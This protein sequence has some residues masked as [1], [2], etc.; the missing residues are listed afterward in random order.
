MAACKVNLQTIAKI[1]Q[2][3]SQKYQTSA[4]KGHNMWKCS[5]ESESIKW[6]TN[7]KLQKSQKWQAKMQLC[8][9]LLLLLYTTAKPLYSFCVYKV[10]LLLLYASKKNNRADLTLTNSRAFMKVLLKNGEGKKWKQISIHH[11]SV[12]TVMYAKMWQRFFF[13][14]LCSYTCVSFSICD[15][16][17]QIVLNVLTSKLHKKYQPFGNFSVFLTCFAIFHSSGGWKMEG[18]RIFLLNVSSWLM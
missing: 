3:K 8:A 12:R 7:K 6:K 15:G 10:L 9:C 5:N 4:C 18:I 14:L 2:H 13:L 16:S 11:T 1:G 17:Q